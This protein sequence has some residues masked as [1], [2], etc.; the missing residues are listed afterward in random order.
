MTKESLTMQ[1]RIEKHIKNIRN[2]QGYGSISEHNL[3]QL[4][5]AYNKLSKEANVKNTNTLL[6]DVKTTLNEHNN[7][8]D[9]LSLSMANMNVTVTDL[10]KQT[11][12]NTEA[13]NW[14]KNILI[15]MANNKPYSQH[16]NRSL[17]SLTGSLCDI[18]ESA[19]IFSFTFNDTSQT[20]NQCICP[21]GYKPYYYYDSDEDT[22]E[23]MGCAKNLL[24]LPFYDKE[25]E[26]HVSVFGGDPNYYAY[27]NNT[28]S[29]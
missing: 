29:N 19:N 18:E 26:L 23:A 25:S 6:L 7:H 12:E 24:T 28:S 3:D 10:N 20:Y 13:I 15:N 21:E 9:Y 1:E 8:F 4:N 14:A 27:A 17:P 22:L 16:Y 5:E 11:Y 2:Q